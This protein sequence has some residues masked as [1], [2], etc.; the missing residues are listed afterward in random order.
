MANNQVLR[1]QVVLMLIE[2]HQLEHARVISKDA[3][4]HADDLA[5]SL[6][7]GKNTAIEDDTI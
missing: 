4:E 6:M 5:T 2:Q 1:Y 7:F 3:T